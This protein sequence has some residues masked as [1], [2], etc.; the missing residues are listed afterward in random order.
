MF[1]FI[2]NMKSQILLA[3]IESCY[4]KVFGIQRGLRI[5]RIHRLR[6]KK[7]WMTNQVYYTSVCRWDHLVSGPDPFP[8]L[9]LSLLETIAYKVS[10]GNTH[11]YTHQNQCS[12]IPALLC[13]TNQRKCFWNKK[14]RHDSFKL[15]RSLFYNS[16]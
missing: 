6:V 14:S 1:S 8:F 16:N 10:K 5:I 4:F 2:R 3:T 12:R 11:A 7:I 9:L 15:T 13:F